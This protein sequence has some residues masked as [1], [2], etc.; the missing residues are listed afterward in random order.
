MF[1]MIVNCSQKVLLNY[2]VNARLIVLIKTSMNKEKRNYEK[3][4]RRGH[5]K[6]KTV[7]IEKEIED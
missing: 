5:G 6:G 3:G 7:K 1:F 2:H 4:N